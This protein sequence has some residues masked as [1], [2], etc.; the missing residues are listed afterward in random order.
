MSKFEVF[1][2]C[3]EK[4][5]VLMTTYVVAAADDRRFWL[6]KVLMNSLCCISS[7]ILGGSSGDMPMAALGTHRL[8][9]LSL[10]GDGY[11][12]MTSFGTNEMCFPLVEPGDPDLVTCV[13]LFFFCS[14]CLC[15][16]I[17]DDDTAVEVED[18][19]VCWVTFWC[20]K[21][22]LVLTID[23]RC[24]DLTELSC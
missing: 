9:D 7:R 12:S 11:S 14:C 13:L 20:W 2:F 1:D 19:E 24:A 4:N 21:L 8:C 18:G 6:L 22:L 10:L 17:A 23:Y 5:A 16:A 3:F 15:L